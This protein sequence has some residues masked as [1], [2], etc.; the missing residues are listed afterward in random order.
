MGVEIEKKYRLDDD[1]RT[2][3]AETL[4]EYGAEFRGEEFEENSIYGGGVLD[5]DRA[6]LRIRKTPVRTLLTYKRRIAGDGDAKQ[7]IEFETEVADASEI[8]QIVAHLGFE[9][10]L[11]YEKRR[12]TW[13]FRE[14]E[15][16]LDEL[17]FGQFMEIEGS[18]TAIIEAEMLLEA[19]D[20]EVVHETYPGL[21]A[22]L[23]KR[24]EGRVEA[25]FED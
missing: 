2:R 20:L 5:L 21:T 4:S 13:K 10:R 23:G 15:V 16:V 8:E 6:V 19:E 17:P 12:R 11:V 22:N 3:I 14:V 1:A 18:L 9:S 25:R 7:Q 24:I